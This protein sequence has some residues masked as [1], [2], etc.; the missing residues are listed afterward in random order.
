MCGWGPY[1]REASVWEAC[2]W[3]SDVINMSWEA[4]CWCS[5][6]INMSWTVARRA[7]RN[8]P[9]AWSGAHPVDRSALPALDSLGVANRD[10]ERL[11][12]RPAAGQHCNCSE[13]PGVGT[14]Y[15]AISV[16]VHA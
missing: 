13:F 4:C 10:P 7:Q 2:C 1:T 12:Q 3:C 11:P 16:Q 5:G 8:R 6:V 14:A 15:R 9:G